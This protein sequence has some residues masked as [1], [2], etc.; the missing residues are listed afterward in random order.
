MENSG[1]NIHMFKYFLIEVL[2]YQRRWGGKID[3]EIIHESP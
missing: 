1:E 3:K 2:G